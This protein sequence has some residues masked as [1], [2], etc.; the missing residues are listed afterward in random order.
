MKTNL[1]QTKY[2]TIII[3]IIIIIIIII[4]IIVIITTI[5]QCFFHGQATQAHGEWS[6]SGSLVQSNIM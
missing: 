1:I 5:L 3:V 6:F 4:T 2:S